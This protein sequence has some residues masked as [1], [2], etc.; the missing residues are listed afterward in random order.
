MQI[1]ICDDDAATRLVLRRQ[2]ERA[3]AECTVQNAV[4]VPTAC[5]PPRHRCST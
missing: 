3:F 4:M 2:F 5:A 1:L